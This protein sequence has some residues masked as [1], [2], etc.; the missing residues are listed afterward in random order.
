MKQNN[1]ITANVATKQN[2]NNRNN[3]N[4][5][6]QGRFYNNCG[7]NSTKQDQNPNRNSNP[8]PY[9]GYCQ[10]RD[11]HDQTAKRCLRFRVS[12]SSLQPQSQQFFQQYSRPPLN[13]QPPFSSPQPRAHFVAQSNDFNMSWLM[14]SGASHHVTYDLQNLSLHL[15]YDGSDDK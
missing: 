11:E 15:E 5:Y 2:P 1:N 8:K 4:T 13:Y 7:N 3:Y 6:K 12:P 10:L 9:K 14:D